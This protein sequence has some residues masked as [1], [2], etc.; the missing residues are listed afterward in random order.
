MTE[1]EN[2]LVSKMILKYV[3]TKNNPLTGLTFKEILQKA[4]EEL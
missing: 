4:K 2:K 3:G 1:E